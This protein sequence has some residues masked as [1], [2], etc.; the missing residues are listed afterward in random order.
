MSAPAPT[1]SAA[2]PSRT[3][4]PTAHQPAAPTMKV[5]QLD[6]FSGDRR[7]LELFLSQCELYARFNPTA[8]AS[9]ANKVLFGATYLREAAADWFQPYLTDFLENNDP[10]DRETE[11][12]TIFNDWAEFKTRITR[13][14]GDIDKERIAERAI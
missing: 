8:L 11:T 1:P 7:K 10:T 9:S 12:N 5:S 6:T 4:P 14:F 3:A 2:G 13:S